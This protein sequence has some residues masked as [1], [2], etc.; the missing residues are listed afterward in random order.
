MNSST[1]LTYIYIYIYIVIYMS[2]YIYIGNRVSARDGREAT[3][4]TPCPLAG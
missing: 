2:I 3:G 4:S 1:V